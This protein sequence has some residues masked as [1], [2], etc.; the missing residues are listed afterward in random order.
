M[1]FRVVNWNM[2]KA[3]K[4]KLTKSLR[5]IW[6]THAPDV[7]LTQESHA[8]FDYV[9]QEWSGTERPLWSPKQLHRPKSEGCA[10][11]AP[12]MVIE[13]IDPGPLQGWVTIGVAT[14]PIG[15]TAIVSLHAPTVTKDHEAFGLRRKTCGT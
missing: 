10:I 5:W 14:L 12:K 7:L 6:E 4:E 2:Q 9:P 15:Q 11:I 13:E 8:P 1:K 3:S